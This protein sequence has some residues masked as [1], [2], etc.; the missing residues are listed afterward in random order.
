[1][2]EAMQSILACSLMALL[3]GIALTTGTFMAAYDNLRIEERRTILCLRL[4]KQHILEGYLM[5]LT[6]F[7]QLALEVHLLIGNL[8]QVDE[9]VQYLVRYEALAISI[10]SVQVDGSDECLKR[11]PTHIAVVHLVVFLASD[12]LVKAYLGC[13]LAKRLTLHD[14]AACISQEAFTLVG[15]MMID[16]LAHDSTQHGI[17][18]ELQPLVVERSPALSM[19]KHR[20]VHQGFLVKSDV[21]RI[22]AQHITKSATKRLFLAKRKLYRVYQVIRLRLNEVKN[23][24]HRLT[25]RI[26]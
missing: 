4:V 12:K 3:L 11:I 7:Q 9:T 26:S 22:E 25:L 23:G 19:R 14:L 2:L 20:L 17:A 1:M 8:V 24:R 21:M 13:Q 5:L 16:N 6:P 15:E 18:Q 10:A